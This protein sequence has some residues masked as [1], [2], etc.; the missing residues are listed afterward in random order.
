MPPVIVPRVGKDIKRLS[1]YNG[2]M[3][4]PVR[5]F[6][7]LHHVLSDGEHWDLGFEV[8]DVLAT[9]QILENPVEAVEAGTAAPAQLPARRIGDHRRAYLEYEGPISRGRGHVVRVD[10]G[11]WR[12]IDES[13]SAWTIRLAGSRLVGV[14]FLRRVSG[15]PEAW[16]FQRRAV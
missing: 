6:V 2:V 16:T 1:A 13:P 3:D 12:L 4:Q 11:P 10:R 9:W 15:S 7:L 8:G 14:F 5:Q